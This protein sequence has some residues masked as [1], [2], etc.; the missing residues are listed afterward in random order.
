MTSWQSCK[1]ILVIRADNM[2]DIIMTTPALRAL[3]ASLHADITMLTSAQGRPICNLIPEINS[4]IVAD[5]PWVKLN[6]QFSA[7]ELNNLI[8]RLKNERFDAA[9]IFTVYSQS[10]LP[11]AL[12]AY[13]AGIPLRL[14]YA[15][16]NPYSLLTHWVPDKEPYSMIKHQVQ[17]DLDL[18]AT[19]GATIQDDRL[20]LSISSDMADRTNQKMFFT[21]IYLPEPYLVFHTGVSET[22]REYPRELWVALIKEVSRITG[23]SILLTGSSAEKN[24][25][26]YLMR[27]GLP[28]V[29][30]VAGLL[31]LDELAVIIKGAEA[32]VSVNTAIVHIAAAMNTPVIVLYALTNP[33]HTP[34]KVPA[35]VLPFSVAASLKSRN[36][37]INFV[38]QQLYSEHIPHPTP[39]DVINALTALIAEARASRENLPERSI[40]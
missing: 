1:K 29:Y 34:W 36:E 16:E 23:R 22:K 15:R 4:V 2:G 20:S 26:A 14:A 35:K 31:N 24:N 28:E 6:E 40:T 30:N 19:V 32:V 9:V 17:R 3:S 8:E 37:I 5:L 18:V 11:A 27:E 12:L 25:V 7:T 33:Q 21:G 10:A 39:A 38:D 13:Q